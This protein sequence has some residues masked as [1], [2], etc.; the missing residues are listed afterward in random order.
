MR[1]PSLYPKD[2]DL[3]GRW[4]VLHRVERSSLSRYVG[5]EIEF[6]VMLEQDGATVTGSGEKF[7]VDWQL[8][9][10]E[11]ASTLTL[12]GRVE[13][14]NV[15]LA[16]TERSPKN[17][18]RTIR[19]EIIWKALTPNRLLGSFKVDAAESSG[20]SRALRREPSGLG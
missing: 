12:E 20:S 19:G 4:Q 14:S 16:I 7:I 13:D 5:L 1:P 11:E 8:A 17:A 2:L 3:T 6:D 10:R 18:E 9:G 15:V